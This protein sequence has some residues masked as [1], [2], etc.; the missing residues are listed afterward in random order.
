MKKTI[1][2][3]ACALMLAGCDWLQDWEKPHARTLPPQPPQAKLIQTADATWIDPAPVQPP[4]V[5][6]VPKPSETAVEMGE[7][8]DHMEQ[9][10]EAMRNEMQT[11]QAVPVMEMPMAPSPEAVAMPAPLTPSAGAAPGSQVVQGAEVK[12]IHFSEDSSRTRVSIDMT[13]ETPFTYDVN[14]EGSILR[15]GLADTKWDGPAAGPVEG[16]KLIT[17]YRAASDGKGG[18]DVFLQL[19]QPVKVLSSQSLPAAGAKGPRVV[20]DLGP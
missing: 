12:D 11:M 13:R 9:Q 7:R 15:V 8:I 10:I 20:I 1:M 3:G 5:H 19:R 4:V 16:S 2:I 6:Y 18:T 14:K 17:A